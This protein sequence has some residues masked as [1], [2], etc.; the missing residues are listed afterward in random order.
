MKQRIRDPNVPYYD[1][2]GGRG[3]DMDPRWEKFEAFVA[4]MG[5]RPPDPEWWTSR[6]GYWSLDRID[7]Q[8]GYWPD[9]CRWATAKE[10]AANKG[11]YLKG[12]A[13]VPDVIM[14]S[15]I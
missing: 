10:Q 14:T 13:I 2:Y 5:E 12:T 9:N 8:R 6:K 1:R 3:L 15:S 11:G 4:D 7:N